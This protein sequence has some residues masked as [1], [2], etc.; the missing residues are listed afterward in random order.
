MTGQIRRRLRI[1]AGDRVADIGCGTGLY[2]RQL[3]GYAGS[4]VCADRSAPMLA[5]IPRDDRLIPVTASVEDVASG[6]VSLP[7]P[8]GFDAVLLKEVLHHVGDRGP[9][10]AGLAG[11]LRPGGRMLVIML[12]ARI[13]YPLFAA[14]VDGRRVAAG[15]ASARQEWRILSRCPGWRRRAFCRLA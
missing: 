7:G 3:A 10:I 9:V 5:Q 2:A 12:P 4:V 8:A 1:K 11:L 13:S 15:T 6:R 14:A